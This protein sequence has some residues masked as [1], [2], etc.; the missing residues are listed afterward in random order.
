MSSDRS[1]RPDADG[2]AESST[3]RLARLAA[4]NE[5]REAENITREANR[6]RCLETALQNA[7]V[8]GATSCACAVGPGVG[9]AH[10]E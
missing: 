5:Q 8:A 10:A 7:L 3:R 6:K 2:A 4:F 9:S 1:D